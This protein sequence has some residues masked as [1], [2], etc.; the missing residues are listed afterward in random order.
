MCYRLF[1]L[2]GMGGWVGAAHV[3]LDE[4]LPSVGILSGSIPAPAFTSPVSPQ[5]N[6][7]H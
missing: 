5:R 2:P 1:R 3:R 7:F 6:T 4:V